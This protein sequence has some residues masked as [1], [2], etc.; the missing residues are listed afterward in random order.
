MALPFSIVQLYAHPFGVDIQEPLGETVTNNIGQWSLTAGPLLAGTYNISAIVIPPAG[1][2]RLMS[3][4]TN[5]NSF[6]FFI[7]MKPEKPSALLHHLQTLTHHKTL[8]LL[9]PSHP[10]QLTRAPLA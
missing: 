9:K 1:L 7:D 5:N 4:T 2:Q 3:L 10:H 8:K 6:A